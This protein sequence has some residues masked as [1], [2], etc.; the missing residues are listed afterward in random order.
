MHAAAVCMMPCPGIRPT[1]QPQR[2]RQWQDPF[3]QVHG[4]LNTGSQHYALPF[5]CD[6]RNF[7]T[8]SCIAISFVDIFV[9][10]KEPVRPSPTPTAR[11]GSAFLTAG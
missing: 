6:S 4:T 8:L 9:D 7:T 2:R 1:R 11:R 10:T 3:L 5:Q